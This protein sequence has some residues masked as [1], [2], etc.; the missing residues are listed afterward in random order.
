[1]QL[2]GPGGPFADPEVIDIMAEI[3][4]LGFIDRFEFTKEQLTQI[5]DLSNQARSVAGSAVADIKSF[6]LPK[7]EEHRDA[8]LKGEKPAK[9]E[10]PEPPEGMLEKGKETKEALDKIVDSFFELL[11]AEQREMLEKM[12]G[13]GFG[14]QPG[15]PGGP[16]PGGPGG[17]GFQGQGGG[18]FGGQWGERQGYK[19]EKPD[20]QNQTP[21]E[22]GSVDNVDNNG[23]TQVAQ[24]PHGNRPFK[25]YD[26]GFQP[27]GGPNAGPPP[28]DAK[29][30]HRGRILELLLDPHTAGVIKEK[31]GYM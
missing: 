18:Q 9:G 25:N 2:I 12:G 21:E 28:G 30:M 14:P 15:G 17:P 11:T 16:G 31:M 13:P 22:A 4:I 10:K 6:M 1:M 23:D 24:K 8:L 3:K 5:A 20:S 27:G 7:L 26:Q 29:M 19:M